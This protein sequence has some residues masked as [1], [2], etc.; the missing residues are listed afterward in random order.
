MI[1]PLFMVFHR[2]MHAA[3]SIGSI[4]MRLAVA[5]M[6]FDLLLHGAGLV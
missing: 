4:A 2:L 1:P 5:A 3:W 6:G